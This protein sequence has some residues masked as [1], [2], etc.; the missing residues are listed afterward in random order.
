MV[1]TRKMVEDEKKS[2]RLR[3]NPAKSKECK[4]FTPHKSAFKEAN[5]VEYL[6]SFCRPVSIRLTRIEC[7]KKKQ[8][9]LPQCHIAESNGI[10]MVFSKFLNTE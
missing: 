3:K 5:S 4:K 10:V 1:Y 8:R 6:L 9:D 7:T 2:K